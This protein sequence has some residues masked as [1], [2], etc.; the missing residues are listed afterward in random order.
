MPNDNIIS[1]DYQLTPRK[2]CLDGEPRYEDHAVN[3]KP[4]DLGWFDDYDVR[5]AA[6]WALFAGAFGHTYGCHPVWQWC[7]DRFEPV[8]FARRHWRQALDL[9]GAFQMRHA[10]RL[11]ESRPMLARIPDQSLLADPKTGPEHRLACRGDDYLMVY[12]PQGG[13]VTVKPHA[14]RDPLLRVWWFDPRT[15]ESRDAGVVSRQEHLE[16]MAPWRGPCSDAV[17]VIDNASVHYPPPGTTLID[18]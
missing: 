2:P 3:W 7:S 9:P 5:Q 6:Y 13:S 10:R 4:Q 14:L 11:L 12:L 17:L 15:G 18:E 16:L 1:H 8:S